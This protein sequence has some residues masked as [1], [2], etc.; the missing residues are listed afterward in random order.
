MCPG[1]GSQRDDL[2]AFLRKSLDDHRVSRAEAKVLDALLE[3][4]QLGKRDLRVLLA[5]AFDLA[6][7]ELVDGR[8]APVLD[9]LQEILR[10][11]VSAHGKG[12][13]V[14]LAEAWFL[15]DEGAVRRLIGLIDSSRKTLDICVFTIT[16]DVLTAAL[17]AAHGRGV[18]LRVITDD[19]KSHDRGSDI[20]R[21][22]QAGIPVRMDDSEA[23]MHHKFAV[24]DSRILLTGSYNWTRSASR[25]NQ[26]NF[27]ISDDPRLSARYASAFDALWRS[28]APPR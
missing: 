19:D 16:N 11:V 17:L 4:Q 10:H 9:W 1:K 15:P 24:F 22:R 25:S 8:D 5:Q 20:A 6:R 2:P 21:M 26:E 14:E 7:G 28:F 12:T 23:H 18:R 3:E 27:L 13:H